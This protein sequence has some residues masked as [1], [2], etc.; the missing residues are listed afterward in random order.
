MICTQ[1]NV[2]KANLARGDCVEAVL[3]KFGVI[4]LE[5]Y[6]IDDPVMCRAGDRSKCYI[7]ASKDL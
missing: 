7:Q 3:L 5:E 2:N 4:S 6:T 1:Q